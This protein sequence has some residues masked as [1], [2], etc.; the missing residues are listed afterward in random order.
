MWIPAN[1][2]IDGVGIGIE[3]SDKD[4]ERRPE[5]DRNPKRKRKGSGDRERVEDGEEKQSRCG[6]V[7]RRRRRE[8]GKQANNWSVCWE[9]ERDAEDAVCPWRSGG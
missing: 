5:K 2:D 3:G 7:G 9:D 4:D 8:E 1:R 6:I